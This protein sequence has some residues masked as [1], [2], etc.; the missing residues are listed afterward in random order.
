MV[1]KGKEE[2]NVILITCDALRADLLA[3]SIE[4]QKL[5]PN[6]RELMES[7][8]RFTSAFSNG[9]GTPSSFPAILTS[10]YPLMYNGYTSELSSKRILLSECLKKENYTTVA[11]HSNPHLSGIFGY[12]RGFDFFHQLGGSKR[13]SFMKEIRNLLFDI[14]ERRREFSV[15][16]DELLQRFYALVQSQL[17]LAYTRASEMNEQIFSWFR[18]YYDDTPLFLWAHY[19][20][21]HTPYVPLLNY[22]RNL[23]FEHMHQYRMYELHYKLLRAK[24]DPDY[25]LSEIERNTL[26]RLYKAEVSYMDEKLGAL[27]SFLKREGLTENSLVILTAD[28]G[29]EFGEHGRYEHEATLYDELLRVPLL[30]KWPLRGSGVVKSLVSLIDLGPTICDFLD[31][32]KPREYQGT[33]LLPLLE[34]KERDKGV[35]SEVSHRGGALKC[36]PERRK[37][38]YRTRD[39]KYIYKANRTDELYY[40]REDPE[41][42]KNL[43]DASKEVAKELKEKINTHLTLIRKSQRPS[44][45]EKI[46]KRI[47]KLGSPSI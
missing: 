5:V 22:R 31:I 43:I 26:F 45:R 19:M 32:E 12:D 40:L 9:P 3:P 28:H 20:D 27:L 38:A 14:L 33:S 36:S 4:S 35:F 25:E 18:R 21:P 16:M 46:K 15:V 23:G 42:T 10:T 13:H 17:P 7:S 30:I 34:G 1:N 6:L 24:R 41:E 11:F 8:V 2:K 37:I 29:E 39:W 47:S 44:L